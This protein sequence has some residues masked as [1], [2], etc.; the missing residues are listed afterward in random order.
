MTGGSA[1]SWVIRRCDQIG[2]V[3]IGVTFCDNHHVTSPCDLGDNLNLIASMS[4]QADFLNFVEDLHTTPTQAQPTPLDS[5][6]P[7]SHSDQTDLVHPPSLPP[8]MIQVPPNVNL[9]PSRRRQ[10]DVP[11]LN[12][13]TLLSGE[14][15][16][17]FLDDQGH[18]Q[19][20]NATHIAGSGCIKYRVKHYEPNEKRL[21]NRQLDR[22][23]AHLK[24]IFLMLDVV[25]PDYHGVFV[26]QSDARLGMVL[27]TESAKSIASSVQ[28]AQLQHAMNL[29]RN[30]ATFGDHIITQRERQEFDG[31]L[32]N[33]TKLDVVDFLKRTQNAK[34]LKALKVRLMNSAPIPFPEPT[35]RP[36]NNANFNW[37][38]VRYTFLNA[39]AHNI[40]KDLADYSNLR[41][42][43]VDKRSYLNLLRSLDMLA[44][45]NN[46]SPLQPA[47]D[48]TGLLHELTDVN[49]RELGT[50]SVSVPESPVLQTSPDPGPG[51][52]IPGTPIDDGDMSLDWESVVEETRLIESPVLPNSY[53]AMNMLPRDPLSDDSDDGGN[54]ATN[55]MLEE[56]LEQE[57]AAMEEEMRAP[58]STF[59]SFNIGNCR[60]ADEE[61]KARPLGTILQE[62][63]AIESVTSQSSVHSQDTPMSPTVAALE[64]AVASTEYRFNRAVLSVV[65]PKLSMVR[66][67][68]TAMQSPERRVLRKR[69]R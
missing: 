19:P 24:R 18:P 23:V 68:A 2:K 51:T 14:A 57:M 15:V 59:S 43:E 10:G 53:L 27:T 56:Q 29:V 62:R 38:V 5:V 61:V 39:S 28:I 54:D 47:A 46:E 1:W 49:E 69:K 4:S 66:A 33:P 34:T 58:R 9:L 26:G 11:A 30:E 13:N 60:R 67:P 17:F 44:I 6:R 64:L 20:S 42:A 36:R 45:A 63:I 7:N 22:L 52:P 3:L 35:P 21:K 25:H 65:V 37:Q 31:K 12:A 8:R 40:W 48:T 50:A 32:P 41:L 16:P 55:R